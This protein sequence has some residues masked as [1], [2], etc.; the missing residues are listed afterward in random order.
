MS[1]ILRHKSKEK[2]E[3]HEVVIVQLPSHVWLC[4]PMDCSTPS[5]PL[6]SP[7]PKACSSSYPLHWWCNPTISSSNVLFFFCPQASGTFP[8]NQLFSSDDQNTGVSASA[9]V[10]SMCIPG[11]FPLR[12][13]GLIRSLLQ[14]QSLKASIFQHSTFFMVQLSQPYMTTEETIALTSGPLLAA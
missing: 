10:L 13:T 9:S 1:L 6:S 7:S 14:H 4:N 5:P 11:L 8:V 12:L 2:K 3:I